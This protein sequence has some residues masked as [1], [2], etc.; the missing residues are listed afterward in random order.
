MLE[1]LD[2][3]HHP[4][5]IHTVVLDGDPHEATALGRAVGRLVVEDV[6]VL[7]PKETRVV[8]QPD[9][10][11]DRLVV[12]DRDDGPSGA[13][14]RTAAPCPGP[15][16]PLPRTLLSPV[17]E[18]R[19]QRMAGAVLGGQHRLA[20][21]RSGGAELG[22]RRRAVR[23]RALRRPAQTAMGPCSTGKPE[24]PKNQFSTAYLGLGIEGSDPVAWR[25]RSSKRRASP[26][27]K[28]GRMI[29]RSPAA[30]SACACDTW[31][32]RTA[33]SVCWVTR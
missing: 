30:F 15:F 17:V 12:D 9:R 2:R 13:G 33:S 29:G 20:G 27:S 25:K 28:M 23:R 7:R 31:I 10:K 11:E 14:G 16:S 19:R 18:P 6:D 8:A 26:G 21:G 5:V 32:E 22:E 24:A 3:L 1:L 4:D